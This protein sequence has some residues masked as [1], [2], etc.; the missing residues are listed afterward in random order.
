MAQTST[1]TGTDTQAL[2]GIR[3][4]NPSKRA[5]ADPRLSPLG[6]WNR[7]HNVYYQF[8]FNIQFQI[9]KFTCLVWKS[10][11]CFGRNVKSPSSNTS[12]LEVTFIFFS[13]QS[14]SV[15]KGDDITT[16]IVPKVEK[17]RSLNLPDP[18]GPAQACSEK[19]LPA[20]STLSRCC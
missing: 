9:L 19:T 13:L 8:H 5:D 16:F 6:H 2:G 1:T 4:L 20:Q 3:T 12:Y 15:R 18:Q 11:M 17:I 7:R 10:F 14:T